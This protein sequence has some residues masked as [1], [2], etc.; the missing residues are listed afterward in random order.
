[1][2]IDSSQFEADQ[3]FSLIRW[4]SFLGL[5]IVV[6]ISVITSYILALF[7]EEH[8]LRRDA[9]VLKDFVEKISQEHDPRGYFS[10]SYAPGDTALNDF[11]RDI[12]HMPDV[13]RINAFDTKGTIVW[14]SDHEMIGQNFPENFELDSALKG[15]L[16]YHRGSLDDSDKPEHADYRKKISWLVENYIPIHE[17]NGT[18]ILGVVEIY[19]IPEALAQSIRQG[20]YLVWLTVSIGFAILYFSLFGVVRRAQNFIEKQQHELVR[21]ARLVTIGEMASSVAHNIRNPIASIR[22]SAEL[23]LDDPANSEIS[24]SMQ[25]IIIEVDRFDGWIRELLTFTSGTGDPDAVS[26]PAEIVNASLEIFRLQAERRGVAIVNRVSSGLPEVR[27]EMYLL[28]QVISSLIANALEAMPQGG[29]LVFNANEGA[30]S[31][32]ITVADSGLGIHPEKLEG[33]FDP[34]VTHKNGGLGIGL[35]LAQRVIH[36]YDGNIDI[37]SMP[38]A[39][40]TVSVELPVAELAP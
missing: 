9:A 21:H 24:E 20:R 18:T 30:S 16:V 40:T 38:G 17:E 32:Q 15:K 7:L 6:L 25:D 11:F 27:G 3:G 10:Q 33:L 34:L 13:A 19:R 36:R 37:S 14:S 31:V 26:E 35:A 28:V 2:A 29:E 1:M 12:A 8:L 23:V 4:F 39:G 5:T 22:S